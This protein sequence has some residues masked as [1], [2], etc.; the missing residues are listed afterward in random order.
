MIDDTYNT[1]CYN[2][3]MKD[4]KKSKYYKQKSMAG[5]RGIEWNLTFD[6]WND[7][8][9]D[10]YYNRGITN[11]KLVMARHGDVGAYELSNIKK[12]TCNE[13]TREAHTRK[14]HPYKANPHLG[15]PGMVGGSKG[16]PLTFEGHTY[17]DI[18]DALQQTGYSRKKIYLRVKKEVA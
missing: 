2:V 17:K 14:Q 4:D 6:Q 3:S 16:K 15:R 11:G 10:D 9:G 8:W 7:W 13:N 5:K 12:I 1:T 18:N